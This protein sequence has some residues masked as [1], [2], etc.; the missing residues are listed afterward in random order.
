MS[1]HKENGQFAKGNQAAKKENGGNGG[2]ARRSV[3]ER[4]LARLAK[5]IDDDDLDKLIQVG[6]ARAKCGDVAWAKLLLSYLIG[7]PIQRT[8]ISGPNQGPIYMTWGEDTGDP[9][10]AAAPIAANGAG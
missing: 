6:L 5:N 10:A 4:C 8:E 7:L 3:E 9:I 2:R 1:D